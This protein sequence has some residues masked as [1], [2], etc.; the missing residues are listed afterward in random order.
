MFKFKSTLLLIIGL[1]VGAMSGYMLGA[2][3]FSAS[4]KGV[5]AI[6]RVEN[7]V[8]PQ[9]IDFAQYWKVWDILRENHIFR[10][11]VTASDMLAGSLKGLASSFNDPYTHYLDQKENQQLTETIEGK[12][13]GIGA[14]LG[15]KENN[16]MVVSP[17]DGSPA[18]E[19]GLKA[20]DYIL[21]VDKTS[22]V[23]MNI[24]EVVN[25]IRGEKG[26]QV[27]L[28]V[29]KEGDSAS[30]D[31]KITRDEIRIDSVKWEDKGDG[32]AYIR[33]SRFGTNTNSEWNTV[34]DKMLTEI[35]TEKLKGVIVDVRQDPGGVLNSAVHL[36]SE[37]IDK[38]VPVIWEEKA[39]GTQTPYKSTRK[40]KLKDLNLNIVVLSD[41]GSASASEILAGALRDE[42]D[43]VIVGTKSF[44][45]G[46]I[47]ESIQ[48]ENNDALNVTIA[49]WLTPNKE[50]VHSVGL[51]P[52]IEV[53]IP[54]DFKVGDTDPQLAKAI[55]LA[56]MSKGSFL[57][58]ILKRVKVF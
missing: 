51:V 28:N 20:G 45:K 42:A 7:Q 57:E 47:Q 3:G 14:E 55:E 33:V 29:I 6:M 37:F 19:A 40:G 24:N 13:S 43:A 11:Q 16:I 17:L 48:L 15:M 38:D 25:L 22:V 30:R 8:S 9:N 18:K 26:T 50:W 41:G 53:K 5:P 52:D 54:D 31:V 35:G 2:N 10:D 4:L 34:I 56:G 49:K 1:V 21:N 23:G 39:D 32:I 27:V 44:G 36:A 46:T 58:N 12:Y